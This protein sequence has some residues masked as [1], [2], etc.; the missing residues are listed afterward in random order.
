MILPLSF[1][2]TLTSGP[3][4]LTRGRHLPSRMWLWNP[5]ATMEIPLLWTS[6]KVV[7][8]LTRLCSSLEA[9]LALVSGE[10]KSLTKCI[11]SY[12]KLLVFSQVC[13]SNYATRW[14]CGIT[15]QCDKSLCTHQVSISHNQT[16]INISLQNDTLRRN[17]SLLNTKHDCIEVH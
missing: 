3:H 2:V 14:C 9:T 7:T 11:I 15:L 13:F 1:S 5:N 16:F 4:T 10:K 8:S 12:Q 17:K 6:C